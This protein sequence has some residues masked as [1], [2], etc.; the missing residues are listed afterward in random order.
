MH[1]A[2]A[3]PQP[4]PD[5]YVLRRL[6]WTSAA[7]ALYAAVNSRTKRQVLVRVW[8]PMPDEADQ[9]RLAQLV[10]SAVAGRSEHVVQILDLEFGG[11]QGNTPVLILEAVKGV[12]LE[13]ALEMHGPMPV[14]RACWLA[15][16]LAETVLECHAWGLRPVLP[17]PQA[18]FLTTYAGRRDFVKLLVPNTLEML[19][20]E[21]AASRDSILVTDILWRA[22]T[23]SP[24]PRDTEPEILESTLLEHRIPPADAEVI[25]RLVADVRHG[26]AALDEVVAR[27]RY[28]GL[29]QPPARDHSLS[30]D[31]RVPPSLVSEEHID[32]TVVERH[33]PVFEETPAPPPPTHFVL[34]KKGALLLAGT[35][36]FLLGSLVTGLVALL[37]LRDKAGSDASE[38]VTEARIQPKLH[39]KPLRMAIAYYS[40]T[41]AVF[42]EMSKLV[43]YLSW[44]LRRP[45]KLV[46]VP[47]AEAA[48]GLDRGTIHLAVFSPY[49]YV[50]TKAKYKHIRLLVS[51]L[52]DG[53]LTYQGFL[54]VR[55]DSPITDIRQL[56]GKRICFVTR[57][58]TSGYLY[59]LALLKAHGLDPERDFSLVRFSGTHEGVVAD[60]AGNRCDVGAVSSPT[61][62][63]RGQRYSLR[64]LAVTERIPGDA[65][66]VTDRLPKETTQAI[67]R[68]Y[69]DFNPRRFLGKSYLGELHRITG[70]Q[71]VDDSHYDSIRRVHLRLFGSLR[72]WLERQK[73]LR[74]SPSHGGPPAARYGNGGVNQPSRTAAPHRNSSR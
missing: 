29:A 16:E 41:Q 17:S 48:R 70:F 32:E 23:S 50:L 52:A 62:F 60:L 61:Y 30:F 24:V 57:T 10:R 33:A 44:A 74:G 54:L 40:P 39:G 47:H 63:D 36:G 43:E 19:E 42:K 38:P 18:I 22:L 31:A 28:S 56:K 20:E 7:S 53:N 27:I 65:Y 64:L 11:P 49:L 66:C 37:L 72:G 8:Q 4:L 69:L 59:P 12:L 25:A 5:K 71:Q 55:A 14:G 21:L 34:T 1:E 6:I 51:H 45:V 73:R 67:L 15:Q 3:L 2:T 13:E 35:L 26:G 58:S 68:A 9:Q 46:D